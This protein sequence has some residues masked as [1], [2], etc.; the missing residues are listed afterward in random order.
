MYYIHFSELKQYKLDIFKEGL[1]LYVNEAFD[2]K[3]KY[4]WYNNNYYHETPPPLVLIN[5]V[6]SVLKKRGIAIPLDYDTLSFLI[7][8]LVYEGWKHSYEN[9]GDYIILD[10]YIIND[11]P[12]VIY[13]THPSLQ[14]LEAFDNGFTGYWLQLDWDGYDDERL[15]NLIE[16]ALLSYLMG[17]TFDKY[18]NGNSDNLPS[19]IHDRLYRDYTK[20]SGELW[21]MKNKTYF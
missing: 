7:S 18:F 8:D 19:F 9:W 12:I 6:H 10:N 21:I 20:I 13:D 2:Y 14:D 5:A 11:K 15:R 3:T 1:K 17:E 16:N 4:G